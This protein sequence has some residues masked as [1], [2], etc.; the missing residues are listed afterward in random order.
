MKR[1]LSRRL[2]FVWNNCLHELR[3][4]R[5]SPE[6]LAPPPPSPNRHL[7][8]FNYFVS[9]SK[10][11]LLLL[12]CSPSDHLLVGY[13]CFPQHVICILRQH[14]NF[15]KF[16]ATPQLLFTAAI[17]VHICA[18]V[19]T[20]LLKDSRVCVWVDESLPVCE[21]RQT[22]TSLHASSKGRSSTQW[23]LHLEPSQSKG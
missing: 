16:H 15:T 21:A 12:V 6:P 2:H 20:F 23:A 8:T 10:C 5:G 3:R 11:R 18:W 22:E 13:V 7:R 14:H 1:H 19:V 9:V 4:V 17:P